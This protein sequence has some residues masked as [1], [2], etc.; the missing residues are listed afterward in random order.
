MDSPDNRA[1]IRQPT[2]E[3]AANQ[4]AGEELPRK[5]DPSTAEKE[6]SRKLDSPDDRA[7]LRRRTREAAANQL[8]REE[9]PR[10]SD[11]PDDKANNRRGARGAAADHLGENPQ[12]AKARERTPCKYRKKAGSCAA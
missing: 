7:D 11:S 1:D 2:R 8:A 12:L 3:A 5:L 4:L 10:K 6:L 9:L